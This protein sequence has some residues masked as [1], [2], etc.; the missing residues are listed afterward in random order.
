M[1]TFNALINDDYISS[2]CSFLSIYDNAQVRLVSSF[3]NKNCSK[4]VN[5]INRAFF[6][7]ITDDIVFNHKD[8]FSNVTQAYYS[9]DSLLTIEGLKEFTNLQ[10]IHISSKNKKTPNLSE[11]K[12]VREVYISAETIIDHTCLSG[13]DIRK[14]NVYYYSIKETELFFHKFKNL[15]DL[16]LC[17]YPDI[18]YDTQN[19]YIQLLSHNLSLKRL[20]LVTDYDIDL[21]NFTTLT[22]LFVYA[23]NMTNDSIKDLSQLEHLEMKWNGKINCIDNMLNLQSYKGHYINLVNKPKIKSIDFSDNCYVPEN[24]S[25]YI[26]SIHSFVDSLENLRLSFFS[27]CG[28]PFNDAGSLNIISNIISNMINLKF[29]SICNDQHDHLYLDLSKM[30]KLEKIDFYNA[31]PIIDHVHSLKKIKIINDK[32]AGHHLYLPVPNKIQK[33]NVKGVI[34]HNL[35]DNLRTFKSS[36]KLEPTDLYALTQNENITRFSITFTIPCS[37]INNTFRDLEYLNL[38]SP[39]S[40]KMVIISLNNLK[41]LKKLW[42]TNCSVKSDCIQHL[43]LS[44]LYLNGIDVHLI[45][46]PQKLKYLHVVKCPKQIITLE[47]FVNLDTIRIDFVG[48]LIG[49]PSTVNIVILPHSN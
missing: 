33:I 18:S 10:N 35:G 31:T 20:T 25:K 39:L 11:L 21:N 15:V 8:F 28:M 37:V 2:I 44:K 48:N 30:T 13:L 19:N 29:L 4:Y 38:D 17:F 34:V 3:F 14:A 45:I 9:D 27:Y 16:T 7:N 47:Q 36:N 42:L 32:H 1:T 41:K 5:K 40:E 12:T 46:N 6:C 24:K 43:E 26:K 22:H 49:K 23:I